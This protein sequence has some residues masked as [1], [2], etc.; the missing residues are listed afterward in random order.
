MMKRDDSDCVEVDFTDKWYTW[1]FSRLKFIEKQRII[2]VQIE[3]WDSVDNE[4]G[5][6]ILKTQTKW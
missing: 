5:N 2:E 3:I 1:Q 4:N 6:I